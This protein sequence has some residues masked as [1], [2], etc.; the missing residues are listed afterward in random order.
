VDP[1]SGHWQAMIS[2][3]NILGPGVIS[4]DY[5]G[6]WGFAQRYLGSLVGDEKLGAFTAHHLHLIAR[7]ASAPFATVELFVEEQS[8]NLLKQIGRP[9]SG[10]LARTA[11]YPKWLQPDAEHVFPQEMRIFDEFGHGETIL[12]TQHVESAP[13]LA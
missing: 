3:A 1:Q 2:R 10:A 13:L 8:G 5:D 6:D 7:D 4:A 11:L 12:M 9:V